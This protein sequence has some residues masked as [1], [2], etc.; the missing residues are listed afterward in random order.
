MSG[1]PGSVYAAEISTM[2]GSEEIDA[3]R[4]LGIP[5]FDYLV[6]PRLVALGATMAPLCA[7]AGAVGILGGFAIAVYMMNISAGAF[8]A[9]LPGAR[10]GG[11][12]LLRAAESHRRLARRRPDAWS[13]RPGA[14]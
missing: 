9:H 13:Q 12:H 11:D 3:L 8:T 5:I 10:A 4:A 2:Q 1:S 7:Y 14:Q 6:L